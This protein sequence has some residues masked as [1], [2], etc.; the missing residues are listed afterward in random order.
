MISRI[1]SIFV[2][3]S[4]L[5]L[6]GC[7]TPRDFDTGGM[8]RA[9]GAAESA[10]QKTVFFAST[11]CTDDPATGAPGSKDRLF[12]DRCWD[13]ALQNEEMLRLGFGLADSGTVRCGSAA[14]TVMPKG[15]SDQSAT[16]VDTPLAIE[17]GSDYSS[18]RQVV[19]NTP[20]KC[21]LILV[22]GFNTTFAFGVKRMA[23][24]ALDLNYDGVPIL[25][26]FAASGR[27]RDYANDTE[28]EVLASPALR[29]LLAELSEGA[30][31]SSPAI[32]VI[33]HSLGT[34][35]TLRVLGE[36]NAPKVRY[37]VLAAPDAD[38]R[39]FLTLAG[40]AIPHMRG[41]TIYTSKFDIAMSASAATHAG[42]SR[43]GE[44]LSATEASDLAGAEI[45]DATARASDPYAHSYF[46][47]S[48]VMVED[49][50]GVLAGIPA[51]DRKRLICAPGDPKSVVACTMP[52]PDGAE[53]GPSLYART[54][55]WILN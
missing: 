27:M 50:R 2:M 32:D 19:L 51:R 31:E 28:A 37:V 40:K 35:M 16:T 20:C 38:P 36:M 1:F 25:F 13:V 29:R 5:A 47:E 54:V 23:Q 53:C 14:V 33:A 42:R 24:M 48:N 10:V 52:C 43:A 39:T 45:I 26:S 46:A 44:G 4:G 3:S 41:L 18:L 15:A 12:S 8:I 9:V 6:S 22:H 34:R 7:V 11:R 17:C 55:H 49:I 30:S 21:A